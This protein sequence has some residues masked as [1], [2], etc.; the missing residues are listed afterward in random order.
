[1]CPEILK[2]GTEGKSGPGMCMGGFFGPLPEG[3]KDLVK[4]MLRLEFQFG[5][6]VWF[7]TGCFRKTTKQTKNRFAQC[8]AN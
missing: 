3:K 1:M 2:R 7:G 5:G 8:Y 6:K 4:T